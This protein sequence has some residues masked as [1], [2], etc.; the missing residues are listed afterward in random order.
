[1][2]G[3]FRKFRIFQ[4]FKEP[5]R[6]LPTLVRMV[7]HHTK[8]GHQRYKRWSHIFQIKV[9]DDPQDGQRPSQGGSLTNQRFVT[10]LILGTGYLGTSIWF[11]T[12]DT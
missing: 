1:M 6:G 4:I 11:L 10:H 7:I 12:F 8:Y 3:Q 9:P 5:E 2:R